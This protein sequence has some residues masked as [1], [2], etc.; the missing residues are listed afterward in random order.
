MDLNLR[1]NIPNSKTHPDSGLSPTSQSIVS[2]S[3]FI[4]VKPRPTSPPSTDVDLSCHCWSV[5]KGCNEV[6]PQILSLMLMLHFLDF[7]GQYLIN[8]SVNDLTSEATPFRF[9]LP[10]VDYVLPPFITSLL[11]LNHTVVDET[12]VIS[13]CCTVNRTNPC[14]FIEEN[15]GRMDGVNRFWR[16]RSL[17]DW[18]GVGLVYCGSTWDIEP[19]TM[20]MRV[21]T[22][23]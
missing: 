6:N 5:C 13:F 12:Q 2:I 3:L 20:S 10:S 22:G 16:R 18:L 23:L 7:I 21:Y 15:R 17:Q 1:I 19:S 14:E 9:S 8:G 11:H 4:S